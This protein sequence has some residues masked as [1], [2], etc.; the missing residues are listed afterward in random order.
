[1]INFASCLA[2]SS[3]QVRE[4]ASFSVSG[5]TIVS[6]SCILRAFMTW[7][8]ERLVVSTQYGEMASSQNSC[9]SV[10]GSIRVEVKQF[11]PPMLRG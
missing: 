1:M 11:A 10:A 5:R 3:L 6:I 2:L 8:Y 9:K 4:V 7:C